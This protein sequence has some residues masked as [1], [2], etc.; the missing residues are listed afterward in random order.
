MTMVLLA[1]GAVTARGMLKLLLRPCVSLMVI[2][3]VFGPCEAPT[4][5]VAENE[6]VLPEAWKLCVLL[7]P[8][9]L[10]APVT[11]RPAL[12]GFVP[13]VTVTVSC[14][15]P[16]AGTVAGTADPIPVGGVG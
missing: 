3:R 15:V 4:S 12:G 7:P 8:I 13:G 9:A 2:A 14:V 5:T 11:V 10:R 16:P 6:N 1:S